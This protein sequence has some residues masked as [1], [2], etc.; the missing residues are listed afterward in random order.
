MYKKS[1][2]KISDSVSEEDI[3]QSTREM[4]DHVSLAQSERAAYQQCITE[5]KSEAEE[6]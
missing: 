6:K 4:Q 3:M 1:R 2:K 5:A